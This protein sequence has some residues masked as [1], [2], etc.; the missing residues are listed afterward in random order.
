MKRTS[1]IASIAIILTSLLSSGGVYAAE[2]TQT[3]DPASASTPV[4]AD[5]TTPQ[6]MTPKP[7]SDLNNPDIT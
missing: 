7:P 3:A 5:L 4:T 2:P 1:M 6:Q